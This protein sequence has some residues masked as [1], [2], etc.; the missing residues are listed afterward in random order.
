MCN[1]MSLHNEMANY[2]AEKQI[3]LISVT[4]PPVNA[5]SHHVRQGIMNGLKRAKEDPNVQAVVLC[6]SGRT[7]PAGADITE[8]A[9]HLATKKP[10]LVEICTE[11]D[12]FPKPVVAAIHGTALGGGL[13]LCLSA[14]Y[15]IA[16]KSAKV[17]FPEVNIGILPGATGTQRLPRVT[18]LKSAIDLIVSGR[19]VNASEAYD[20]GIVDQIVDSDVV[21]KASEFAKSIVMRPL[22]PRR[23]SSMPVKGIEHASTIFE[24]ARQKTIRRSRGAIAPLTCIQAIQASVEQPTF[25]KGVQKESELMYYLMQSGQARAQ[26]YA[27]FAE[28]SVSK[29]QRPNG[30]SYKTTKPVRVKTAAVIGAG[31]M[32]V[33]IA[34][35]LISCGVKVFLTEQNQEYLNRG[36]EILKN[37]IFSGVKRNRISKSQAEKLVSLVT[38]VLDYGSFSHVDIVIEAV[39]ENMDIK[40]KVFRKLDAVCKPSAILASNTS[41]LNIDEIASVTSQPDKVVGMHFFSP[42]HIM[43]LLENIYGKATSSETIATAMD[44]GQRM[45][46]ISVLVGNCH[47]FV[48]N[49]MMG[50]YTAEAGFLLEEGCFPQDV[51]QALRDFGFAMGAFQTSDLAGADIGYKIRKELGLVGPRWADERLRMGQRYSPLGDM[52]VEAGRLG[53]KTGKGWYNYGKP[54]GRANMRDV[55]V[56]EIIVNFSKKHDI[57]R[58]RISPQEII[59]RCLYSLINEGFKA[60]EEGIA[61]KDEDIDIIWIY[62]YGWPR[63]MGGPMYY[64]KNMVGLPKVYERI[65]HYH[66]IYKNSKH[67]IPSTLLKQMALSQSASKL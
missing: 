5:L 63:H 3:A 31:T 53:Q 56:E 30:V 26:Q 33:G 28:R 2:S 13:E 60:L 16:S 15:R 7:F 55:E 43:K 54:G 14:H 23:V 44:L 27:F 66:S 62:G 58:R 20:L 24:E 4:N 59:E 35:S 46:K 47:G 49:R 6:G 8:F 11:L 40:K 1:C 36:M 57:K 29:W 9:S 34:V 51:D 32:G 45:K 22:G 39:F 41:T 18:H 38:P 42:A 17:G 61:A 21:S 50:P 65:C 19:Q 48:G 37:I 12:S 10:H 52:I 64:A 67:W 25:E